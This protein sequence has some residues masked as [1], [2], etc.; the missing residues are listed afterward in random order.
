MYV[1]MSRQ[2]DALYMNLIKQ[3]ATLGLVLW[4][5]L[6]HVSSTAQATMQ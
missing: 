4:S 1:H 6:F 3:S 2:R 5:H